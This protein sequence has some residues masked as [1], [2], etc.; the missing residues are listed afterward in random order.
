[1]TRTIDAP[2]RSRRRPALALVAI[3][4]F[5]VALTGCTPEQQA[6][7]DQ[8][9]AARTQAGVPTVLPSPHAMDKAQ[10]WANQLAGVG[11]LSHSSLTDGMPEGWRMLGENVGMGPSI[12]AVF[13][14]FL[15]SP[16][17]R[18]NLLNGS[19]NWAG[20]GVAIAADG[21]VYVVQVFARY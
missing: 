16:K 7:L 17:H 12:E 13:Q 21:T 1:V 18:A 4:A 9:N 15:Q 8:I 20:T 5:L 11:S 14:G 2:R 10:A 6:T 19:F 3:L